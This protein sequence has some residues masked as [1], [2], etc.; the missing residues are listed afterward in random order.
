MTNTLNWHTKRIALPEINTNLLSAV[1]L[2]LLF[3]IALRNNYEI[4]F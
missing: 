3:T 1:S 4:Q 2:I